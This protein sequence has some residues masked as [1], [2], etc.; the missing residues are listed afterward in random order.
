MAKW[1][2]DLNWDFIK[3]NLVKSKLENL[4]YS[5]VTPASKNIS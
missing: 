2:K 4:T 3:I 5:V 1:I